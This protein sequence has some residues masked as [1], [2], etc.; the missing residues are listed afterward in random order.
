M[1]SLYFVYSALLTA[2]KADT[3]THPLAT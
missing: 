2:L 3:V 1:I